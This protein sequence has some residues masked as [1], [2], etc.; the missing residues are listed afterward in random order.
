M[1]IVSSTS[2]YECFNEVVIIVALLSG[3]LYA[4]YGYKKDAAKYY[5]A[6]EAN[7]RKDYFAN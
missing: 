4:F 2:A 7:A 6:L 3:L 5:K 1:C